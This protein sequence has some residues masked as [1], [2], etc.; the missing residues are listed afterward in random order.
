M[1]R[2][3]RASEQAN[4]IAQESIRKRLDSSRV[5]KDSPRTGILKRKNINGEDGAMLN[6]KTRLK[7]RNNVA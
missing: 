2:G 3:N 6:F 1:I 7:Q 5:Q 4:R